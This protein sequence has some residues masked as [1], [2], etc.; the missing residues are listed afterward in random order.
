LGVGRSF[1]F[2]SDVGSFD[3]KNALL[4]ARRGLSDAPRLTEER[5]I[6]IPEIDLDW[7]QIDLQISSGQWSACTARHSTSAGRGPDLTAA[8]SATVGRGGL[9]CGRS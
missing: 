6:E 8:G 1:G 4:S 3:G 5:M 9:D 7:R 2:D